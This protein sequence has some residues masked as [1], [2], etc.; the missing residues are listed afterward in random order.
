MLLYVP[1]SLFIL[2]HPHQN[3]KKKKTVDCHTQ[4]VLT[5][6]LPKTL[7]VIRFSTLKL[8]VLLWLPD[9]G[10]HTMENPKYLTWP[11]PLKP[12]PHTNKHSETS[13]FN[14]IH[15]SMAILVL[16]VC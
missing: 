9:T 11:I 13:T 15:N 4:N 5:E 8:N 14:G 16:T 2:S 7:L 6:E 1:F 10:C 12:V 3:E